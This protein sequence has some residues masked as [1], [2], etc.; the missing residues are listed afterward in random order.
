[1]CILSTV[2]ETDQMVIEIHGLGSETKEKVDEMI[3]YFEKDDYNHYLISDMK[4]CYK[5]ISEATGRAYD[6]IKSEGH[7]SKKGH[8]LAE[9][10]ALH[11]E[12][13]LL[14]QSTGES[15]FVIYRDIWIF[16]AYTRKLSIR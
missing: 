6:E 12:I 15:L 2:D 11:N 14:Y 3:S 7:I 13:E 9:L 4:Q 5:N 16:S 10:N 1:M 8:S